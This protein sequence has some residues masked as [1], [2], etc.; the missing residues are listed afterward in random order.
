MPE[1]S[2]SQWNRIKDALLGEAQ[3]SGGSAITR[4]RVW[5]VFHKDSC[6]L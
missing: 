4:E 2:E 5:W 1:L 6:R 3:K